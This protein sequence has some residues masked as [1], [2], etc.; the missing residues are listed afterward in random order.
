MVRVKQNT[1]ICMYWGCVFLKGLTT[2]LPITAI[3]T[4]F[5]P[6]LVYFYFWQATWPGENHFHFWAS[7][8]SLKSEKFVFHT[9]LLGPWKWDR[10]R[11]E[12]GDSTWGF[13]WSSLRLSFISFKRW[14]VSSPWDTTCCLKVSE[15]HCTRWSL[16]FL[17]ALSIYDYICLISSVSQYNLVG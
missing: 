9:V 17:P 15:N 4:L 10:R 16:K 8:S 2:V 7:V 5:I 14:T 13:D 6:S 3:S 11:G 1:R 12:E